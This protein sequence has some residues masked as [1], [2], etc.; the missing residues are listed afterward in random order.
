MKKHT[1]IIEKITSK[2]FKL[3]AN[4]LKEAIENYNE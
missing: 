2:L 4:S 3:E 1:M